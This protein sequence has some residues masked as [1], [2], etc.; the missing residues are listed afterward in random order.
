[1]RPPSSERE[2][3]S[4]GLWSEHETRCPQAEEVHLPLDEL[5]RSDAHGGPGNHI[6]QPMLLLAQPGP[7]GAGRN[8]E[9]ADRGPFLSDG[10]TERSRQRVGVGRMSGGE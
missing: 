2:A 5:G 9:Q 7:G 10:V 4:H 8:R 3:H 6:A 1:M